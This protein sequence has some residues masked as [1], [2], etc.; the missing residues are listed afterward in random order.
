M[1]VLTSIREDICAS[2]ASP[3]RTNPGVKIRSVLFAAS[4][5]EIS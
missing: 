5:G 2:V 4:A 1:E 3:T